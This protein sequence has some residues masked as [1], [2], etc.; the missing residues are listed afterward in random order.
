MERSGFVRNLRWN[1]AQ[2]P[3]LYFPST[4]FS[5]AHHPKAGTVLIVMYLTYT[6]A[7]I[8]HL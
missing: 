4:A 2:V 3:E 7:L 1:Q 8:Y 5:G 6:A